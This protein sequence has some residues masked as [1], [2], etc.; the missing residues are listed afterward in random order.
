MRSLRWRSRT[1]RQHSRRRL[2]IPKSSKARPP[3]SRHPRRSP[4][5]LR[6]KRNAGATGLP[7]LNDGRSETE[8]QMGNR[9]QQIEGYYLCKGTDR[10]V[11]EIRDGK[12][13]DGEPAW[14]PD[15]RRPD[16]FYWCYL[17]DD[18]R[19]RNGRLNGPHPSLEAA[20]ASAF[21]PNLHQQVEL[22]VEELAACGVL[23]SRVRAD[24]VREYWLSDDAAGGLPE[25]KL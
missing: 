9:K 25:C 4:S 2:A 6:P 10:G 21:A 15:A 3:R 5:G 17:N 1:S 16:G 19:I 23:E 11:V 14:L 13:Y 12:F 8:E 18:H 20:A 24:G 7:I 22:A